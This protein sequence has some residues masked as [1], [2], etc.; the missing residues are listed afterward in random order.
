MTKEL[1][2][3]MAVSDNDKENSVN[4]IMKRANLIAESN[5]VMKLFSNSDI[6]FAEFSDYVKENSTQREKDLLFVSEFL[7]KVWYTLHVDYQVLKEP[8]TETNKK[9]I[10]SLKSALDNL[11]LTHLLTNDLNSKTLK[12]IN[13]LCKEDKKNKLK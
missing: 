10:K 6:I 2:M 7:T 11:N 9:D 5:N 1:I 4:K 3:T 8:L 12:L 13:D